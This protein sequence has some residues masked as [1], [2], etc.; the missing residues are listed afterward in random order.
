MFNENSNNKIVLY[1]KRFFL[2][3][4]INVVDNIVFLGG[5]YRNARENIKSIKSKFNF[6]FC[7]DNE[8]WSSNEIN[9]S[10][11]EGILFIGNDGKRF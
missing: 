5:K 9:M 7:V 2:N 4:L 11:K 8:F 6:P 10:Q 1:L 3:S